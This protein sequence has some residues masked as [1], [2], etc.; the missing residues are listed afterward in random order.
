MQEF[1]YKFKKKIILIYGYG[2]SG[3]ASFKY[4]KKYNKVFIYDD[5]KK[6]KNLPFVELKKIN[7]LIFDYILLSPGINIRKCK[8]KKI[9]N[10]NKKKIITDLDI[11]YSF[12]PKILK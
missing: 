8:L 3:S 6:I 11:F 4:L 10:K 7:Q 9:L 5:F 2:K 1:K 12:Y